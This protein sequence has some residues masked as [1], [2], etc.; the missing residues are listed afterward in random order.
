M[1]I[2]ARYGQLASNQ[3]QFANTCSSRDIIDP[4]IDRAL[5]KVFR[6]DLLNYRLIEPDKSLSQSHRRARRPALL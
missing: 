1:R 4:T 3:A 5:I 2:R 6:A